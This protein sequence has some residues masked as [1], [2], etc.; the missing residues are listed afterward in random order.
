M[1]KLKLF[2]F[3]LRQRGLDPWSGN[4]DPTCCAVQ[5]KE[6]KEIWDYLHKTE[7]IIHGVSLSRIKK[8]NPQS[9][10]KFKFF[11]RLHDEYEDLCP[12]HSEVEIDGELEIVILAT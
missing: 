12:S 1:V 2:T 7:Q 6:K 10:P 3:Q 8:K 5:S 4:Q 9:L 11:C